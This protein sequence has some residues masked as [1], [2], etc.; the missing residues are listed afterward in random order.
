MM[1]R[2]LKLLLINLKEEEDVLVRTKNPRQREMKNPHQ[3][4][5]EQTNKQINKINKYIISVPLLSPHYC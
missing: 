4:K 5:N 3:Q 1:C 2:I